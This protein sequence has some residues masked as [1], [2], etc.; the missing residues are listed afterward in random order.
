[1][2]SMN[3][4]LKISNILCTSAD[5]LLTCKSADDVSAVGKA[6]QYCILAVP[7]TRQRDCREVLKTHSSF[8][9]QRFSRIQ[10]A[11]V[12]ESMIQQRFP[13]GVTEGMIQQ[14]LHLLI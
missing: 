10:I 6:Y 9:T 3:C 13:N 11:S 8:T 4:F 2:T 12:P 1:M 7:V 5:A 14:W